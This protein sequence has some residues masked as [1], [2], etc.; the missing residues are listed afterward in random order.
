[1]SGNTEFTTNCT[2]LKSKKARPDL[3]KL[4]F[5]RK[6]ETKMKLELNDGKSRSRERARELKQTPA[7]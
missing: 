5:A 6:K 1:M 4:G 7:A 2:P 3:G